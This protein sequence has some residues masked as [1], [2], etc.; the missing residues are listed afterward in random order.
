MSKDKKYS[1]LTGLVHS[2]CKPYRTDSYFKA[3][4]ALIYRWIVFGRGWIL[5]VKP[6]H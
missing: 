5:K 1:V 4:I 3:V 2:Y 6:N